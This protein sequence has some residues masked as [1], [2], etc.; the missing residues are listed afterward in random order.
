M[1]GDCKVTVIMSNYNQEKYVSCAIESVLNQKVDFAF[2]LII[3]DDFS[4]KDRSLEIIKRYEA[5]YPEKI[6]VL[7]NQENG[8][9]LKNVLRAKAITKTPYFCLLDADDCWT[10]MNY[11]QD[12]VDFLDSHLDYVIY[13][14]NVVCQSEDGS[15]HL[16]VLKNIPAS[17]FTLDDYFKHSICMTQTTGTFFRNVIFINGVPNIMEKAVGTISERSFEGDFDRYLMHLKYGKAHYDPK[18]SGIYRLLTSGIW[19]RL[20]EFEKNIIQAQCYLDY[21]AYFEDKYDAFFSNEAY[22]TLSCCV[23]ALNELNQDFSL[24]DLHREMFFN[25]A[26]WLHKKRK[27]ISAF[28]DVKPNGKKV[29]LKYRIL[30]FIYDKMRKRLRKKGLV[31]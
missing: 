25:V 24:S 28:D 20:T 10:D 12:A 14:R 18:P 9:Y 21:N 5:Q 3:T 7:Y 19:S 29:K 11:L 8:G 17:D 4:T 16:F 6:K 15:E 2:Q 1:C 13:S 22:K 23:T 31:K 30:L 27:L 26:S